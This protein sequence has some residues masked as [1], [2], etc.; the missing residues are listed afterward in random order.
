MAAASHGYMNKDPHRYDDMLHLPHHQSATRP[1]MALSD[2]AAQ[3]SPFA[4]LVGYDEA[5]KETARLTD[6]RIELDE[7]SKAMLDDRLQILREHL[8]E[9]P[10]ISFTHFIPDALKDGGSYITTTGIVKKIDLYSRKIILYADN[11]MLSDKGLTID[12]DNIIAISGSLFQK[13]EFFL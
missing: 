7:S 5:V 2:R 13:M 4:A 12:I 8:Q 10:V 9:R 11:G 3:F 6:E 1:H